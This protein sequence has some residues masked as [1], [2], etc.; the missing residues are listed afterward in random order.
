LKRSWEF[1]CRPK[2]LNL[3]NRMP[4]YT[5]LAKDKDGNVVKDSLQAKSR[6]EAVAALKDRGLFVIH[7]SSSG[8]GR[9]GSK[10]G[11]GI[12]KKR[13]SPF[14]FL[15]RSRVT[16]S[17]LSVFCRQ[18][19]VCVV[20]G[21]NLI[22]ALESIA[23]DMDNHYFRKVLFD[24]TASIRNGKSFSDSIAR[25]EKVFGPLFISLM[26]AAEESGSIHTVLE[27][28][29]LYLEKRLRLERKIQSITAYPIFVAAFFLIVITVVTLFIL[30]RFENLFSTFG[31]QLP[32]F[33]K[34]V[35]GINGFIVHNIFLLITIIIGI[36]A[37]FIIYGRTPKGMY[38]IDQ[39]KLNIPIFGELVRKTAIARFCRILSITIRGGVPIVTAISITSGSCG[40]KV[41]EKSLERVQAQVTDGSDIAGSLGEDEDFPRMV[42]RMVNVGETSGRLPEVL[43]KVSD[44]YEDEIDGSITIATSLFEPVVLVVFGG[45]V[46]MLVL[47]I[48]IPIFSI[49]MRMRGG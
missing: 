12:V 41:L 35:F 43:D 46:L 47:A 42:V 21:I 37:G 49:A 24:I 32:F 30:P 18:L 15:F 27:Y 3:G 5:F 10:K 38:N 19:S 33:T 28:L 6:Y 22:E 16:M 34:V 1:A 17:E 11:F 45:I 9:A 8:L 4:G 13:Q 48:Y 2:P 29:S 14:S 20:S 23:D 31:S 7:I 25:H 26:K 44:I 39:L 36:I 40:N